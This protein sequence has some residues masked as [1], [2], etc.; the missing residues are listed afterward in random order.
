MNEH[1]IAHGLKQSTMAIASEEQP[2]ILQKR[3]MDAEFSEIIDLFDA[4]NRELTDK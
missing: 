4:S 2:E 1:T 3:D